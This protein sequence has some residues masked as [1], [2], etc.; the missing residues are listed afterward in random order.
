M[1]QNTDIKLEA[2]RLRLLAAVLELQHYT[3]TESNIVPIPGGDRVIAI[4]TPVQVRELL[5]DDTSGSDGTAAAG[6][7]AIEIAA[8]IFNFKPHKQPEEVIARY[9][10]F[11]DAIL[12]SRAVISESELVGVIATLPPPSTYGEQA[13]AYTDGPLWDEDAVRKAQRVAIAQHATSGSELAT[14]QPAALTG[15]AAGAVFQPLADELE[16]FEAHAKRKHLSTDGVTIRGQRVYSNEKTQAAANAWQARA[17][18]AQQAG[19]PALLN[20]DELAALRRFNETC[21]DGEGYDVPKPMM[22]RLSEIGVV[23]RLSGAYYHVT[24]FGMR[25]LEG[26]A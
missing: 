23:Q 2:K 8:R 20:A 6:A 14:C 11:A 25:V 5:A 22:R 13:D 9:L 4:G 26:G 15:Q 1:D 12:A 21:E 7:V 18:L 19:A 24:E 17:A 3:S 10:R 16:Q